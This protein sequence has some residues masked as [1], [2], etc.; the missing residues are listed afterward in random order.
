MEP[1]R[2]ETLLVERRDAVDW[3]TLNRP[4]RLNAL[5]RQLSADLGDYFAG[6]YRRHEVRIVVLRGVRRS[7]AIAETRAIKRAH[8]AW[9]S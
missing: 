9:T 8:S 3:V 2:F 5:N 6:L 7:T 4:E 1:A